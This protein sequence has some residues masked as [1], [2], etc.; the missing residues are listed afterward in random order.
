MLF[1]LTLTFLASQIFAFLAII[2][3]FLSFQFKERKH[4]LL[5][6]TLSCVFITI[7]YFLLGEINAGILLTISALSFLVSSFSHDKRWM[8][9][10]FILY[11]LP[12]TLNYTSWH[13]LLLFFALY[14]ILIGK[15]QKND[16][17]IRLFIMGATLLTITY[18]ILIFT[19]MGV[20][21]EVLFLSSNILG[22]YRHYLRKK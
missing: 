21:L 17:R 3:D 11:L 4:I 15:F 16:K 14:I 22:F 1:W 6:L 7:H 5:I 8:Y 13:D 12:V 2:T 18:N 20:L 9:V 10:F 19:P